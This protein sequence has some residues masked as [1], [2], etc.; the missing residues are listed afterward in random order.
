LLDGDG[1]GLNNFEEARYGTDPHNRDTDGDGWSDGDEVRYGSNPLDPR[2]TPPQ[3]TTARGW[4][5]YR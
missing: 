5:L 4:R 1:D 3:Y 2:S